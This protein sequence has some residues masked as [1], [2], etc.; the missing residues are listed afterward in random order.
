MIR[1]TRFLLA[2]LGATLALLPLSARAIVMQGLSLEELTRRAD[3]VVHGEVLAQSVRKEGKNLWTT[4]RLRVID[5]LKGSAPG[6]TL[7]FDQLGGS[8]DGRTVRI[9]GDAS[10]APGEEVVVFLARTPE[11]LV[12]YGFSQG[13]FVVA[14]DPVANAPLVTRD[15]SEATLVTPRG[16][17][18]ARQWAAPTL[19]DF[20][21]EIRAFANAR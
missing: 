2:A 4:T 11:G 12:L 16:Q 21:A 6:A 17:A 19:D 20:R 1:S 5:T 13:K 8:L 9:A 7:G 15:L 10:F 3:L 18:P 14:F